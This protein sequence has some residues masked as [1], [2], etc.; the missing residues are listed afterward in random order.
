LSW[1]GNFRCSFFSTWGS[2]LRLLM[3]I[4]TGQ[5]LFSSR[6]RLFFCSFSKG[7]L[8]WS[9]IFV[10]LDYLFKSDSWLL[11]ID[12]ILEFIVFWEFTSMFKSYCSW[13]FVFVDIGGDGNGLISNKVFLLILGLIHVEEK[14]SPSVSVKWRNIE[15]DG[16]AGH[17]HD[18][19]S[20]DFS[21]GGF[22]G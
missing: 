11:D 17:E 10:L 22:Y 15:I 8:K 13:F 7:W 6:L 19:F 2:S 21:E 1:R 3:V 5:S 16:T 18:V 12:L 20:I 9:L 4:V 14:L